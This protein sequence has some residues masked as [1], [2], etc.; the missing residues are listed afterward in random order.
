LL[1]EVR[2][3]KPAGHRFLFREATLDDAVAL[4]CLTHCPRRPTPSISTSF[5]PTGPS[6]ASNPPVSNPSLPFQSI[7][8]IQKR[9]L[10]DAACFGHQFGSLAEDCNL[11]APLVG[12]ARASHGM[13]R[14]RSTPINSMRAKGLEE[15][16]ILGSQLLE[17][18]S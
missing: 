2:V 6:G 13:S 10:G 16:S 8:Y 9:S 3:P 4:M 14:Y 15:E 12:H 18:C 5:F 11:A 7:L 17:P 1:P